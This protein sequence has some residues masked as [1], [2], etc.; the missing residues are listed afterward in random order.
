[1]PSL[2]GW[3]LGLLRRFGPPQPYNWTCPP[4]QAGANTK[5][6]SGHQD[7]KV[8]GGVSDPNSAFTDD[9]QVVMVFCPVPSTQGRRSSGGHRSLP[10]CPTPAGIRFSRTS[11]TSRD[12]S[13]VKPAN[14]VIRY[15]NLLA[16]P[17]DVTSP[18]IHPVHGSRSARAQT[19]QPFTI[20]TTRVNSAM[21][22]R[23]TRR[24]RRRLAR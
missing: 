22:A 11:I 1:M 9:G 7:I 17:S 16:D 20:D 21:S 8:L 18:R 4:P 2:P 15:S 24:P 6:S 23:D 13:L 10:T 14:L 19:A 3:S 5:P 12:C